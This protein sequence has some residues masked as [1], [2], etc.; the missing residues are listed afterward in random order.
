MP[1]LIVDTHVH[2]FDRNTPMLED[3]WWPNGEEA[4]VEDLMAC[5][6][7]YGISYGVL[8]T[9]SIYGY[10]NDDFRHALKRFP[11]LR[12]TANLPP[13]AD[14]HA[15]E[16]MSREGF[17]G[18][19]LLWH[20]DGHVADLISDANRRL[21]RRCADHGWH[22]HL[23]DRPDR[24]GATIAALEAS[25]VRV[26]VDHMGMID[27]QA[28]IDDPGFRAILDAIDRGRTWVK[29]SG[30]FRYRNPQNAKAA[31]R[32]LVAAGGWDR[33][34]WGSDWPFVGYMGNVTYR[35]TLAYLDWVEDGD[36][37]RRVAALTALDFYF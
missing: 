36:M 27:T 24:I 11:R 28:G 22:V 18:I 23:T 35:D 9:A 31:A 4:P 30:A 19:R 15:F 13:D 33:L 5:F 34:M 37:R 17:L 12:A 3:K 21:L 6:V 10:F 26:V 8:S 25:G 14:A 2:I 32:A 20:G 1:D 29:L 16:Q 7:A